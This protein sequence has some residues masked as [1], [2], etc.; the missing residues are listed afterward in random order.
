MYLFKTEPQMNLVQ[1][2]FMILTKYLS[3]FIKK[4]KKPV[5]APRHAV[6]RLVLLL[7][8][9]FKIIKLIPALE[10]LFVLPLAFLM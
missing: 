2:N 1:L 6:K 4:K 9:T 7:Q 3:L 10:E 5:Y 8:K